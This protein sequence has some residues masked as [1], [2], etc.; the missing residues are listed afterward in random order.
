MQVAAVAQ[1]TRVVLLVQEVLEAAAMVVITRLALLDLLHLVTQTQAVVAVDIY[2]QL[3]I[4]VQLA[5]PAL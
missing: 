1:V 4:M 2:T 5:D 3:D